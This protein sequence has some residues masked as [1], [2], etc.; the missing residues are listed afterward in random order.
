MHVIWRDNLQDEAYLKAGTL[1]TGLLRDRVMA[2]YDPARVSKIT[3][4]ARKEI[5][6]LGHLYAETHPSLIRLNYGLQRHHGGGMAVRTIACLPA[7]V[8]AW[9]HPGGGAM[10]STSGDV[11]I[12]L[13]EAHPARSLA[14]RH[15]NGQHE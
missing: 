14:P 1:G 10:L 3:G 5:E 6:S 2:E 11:R 4:L 7:I 12:Q 15:A 13:G 9:K 8:G